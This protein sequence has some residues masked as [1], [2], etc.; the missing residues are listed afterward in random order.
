LNRRGIVNGGG[1][2]AE[3]SSTD[4]SLFAQEMKYL[5][6]DGFTVLNDNGKSPV[7]SK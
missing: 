7:Q 6:D 1:G 3:G 2:G 4:V 5:H